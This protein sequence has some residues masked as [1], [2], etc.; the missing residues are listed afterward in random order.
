MDLTQAAARGP[1]ANRVP[2]LG[3]YLS[4]WLADVI[5]PNSGPA[6]TANY[7]MFV[8][9]SIVPTLGTKRLDKLGARDVQKWLNT[10]VSHPP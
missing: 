4:E 5:R 8:E 7:A 3:A 1:V 6:T 2:T 9:L 10:T